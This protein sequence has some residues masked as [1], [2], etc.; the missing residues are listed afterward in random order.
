MGALVWLIE[1]GGQHFICGFILLGSCVT[2][3]AMRRHAGRRELSR[4][5]VVIVANDR[6]GLPESRPPIVG[7]YRPPEREDRLRYDEASCCTW[8]DLVSLG[9]SNGV[10]SRLA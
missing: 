2:S 6:R 10:F 1:A 5:R 7:Q 8:K 9:G 3:Q 4:R